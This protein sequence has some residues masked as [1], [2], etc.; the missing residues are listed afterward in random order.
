MML[1]QLI[2]DPEPA[3]SLAAH[4]ALQAVLERYLANPAE[5]KVK[6]EGRADALRFETVAR[7]VTLTIRSVATCSGLRGARPW[8]P[9]PARALT[10][11]SP[12]CPYVPRCT[13]TPAVQ[14]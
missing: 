4:V 5:I 2:R 6:V 3:V 14:T 13:V 10:V 12:P 11:A 8:L 7:V 9:W 1:L